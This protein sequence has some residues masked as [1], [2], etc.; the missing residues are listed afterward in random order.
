[1][2]GDVERPTAAPTTTSTADPTAATDP[3]VG[4]APAERH[5][6]VAALART[7]AA[8]SGRFTLERHLGTGPGAPPAVVL[9]GRW[10]R[11]SDR[12]EA[13]ID[14]G[15]ARALVDPDGELDGRSARL[16]ARRI[17][18]RHVVRRP[19]GPWEAVEPGELGADDE[20]GAVLHLAAGAR[21]WD[22]PHPGAA[23]DGTRVARWHGELTRPEVATTV[24]PTLAPAVAV[25]ARGRAEVWVDTD[26]WARRVDVALDP[27]SLSWAGIARPTLDELARVGSFDLR[28]ATWWEDLGRPQVIEVPPVAP[29]PPG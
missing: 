7:A 16:E 25:G 5:P 8:P 4:P 22:G 26:G 28:V 20:L 10:D 12:A 6:V 27:T 23:A 15:G 2:P 24:L 21:R 14:T 13:R 3:L 18:D 17:G 29:A 1:V 19:G 9:R 11:P